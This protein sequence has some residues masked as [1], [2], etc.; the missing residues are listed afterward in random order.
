[1]IKILVVCLLL[2]GCVPIHKVV[3]IRSYGPAG[4]TETYSYEGPNDP[5]EVIRKLVEEK[6]ERRFR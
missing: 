5:V 1:M 4:I 3:A 2:G 6:K